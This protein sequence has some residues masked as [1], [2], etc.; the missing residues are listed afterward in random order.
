MAEEIIV[1]AEVILAAVP[2][3][4]DGNSRWLVVEFAIRNLA[5]R[6]T[7]LEQAVRYMWEYVQKAGTTEKL[8]EED[9]HNLVEYL[10]T[11]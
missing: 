7:T 3:A 5:E 8:T 6:D 9:L 2:L 4:G 11:L 10:R 1:R